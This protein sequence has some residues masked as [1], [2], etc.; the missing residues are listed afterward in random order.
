[1]NVLQ[2]R[3]SQRTHDRT[4]E[5]L[6]QISRQS[7]C[8]VGLSWTKCDPTTHLVQ[9]LIKNEQHK[10]VQ[11]NPPFVKDVYLQLP[12]EADAG[13]GKCDSTVGFLVS[14]RWPRL[15]RRPAGGLGIREE[16]GH[17]CGFQA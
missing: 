7:V 2:K 4:Q 14:A 10:K 16:T 8:F 11:L 17:T 15:V 1:M 13:E 3:S 12:N 9:K 6:E 5:I